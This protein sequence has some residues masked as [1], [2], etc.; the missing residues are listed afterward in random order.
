MPEYFE[1]GTY[2]IVVRPFGKKHRDACN[3][4]KDSNKLPQALHFNRSFSFSSYTNFVVLPSASFWDFT[5]PF[6]YAS[7]SEE[8]GDLYFGDSSDVLAK[9]AGQSSLYKFPGEG[10]TVISGHNT[11]IFKNLFKLKEEDEVVIETVYGKFNYKVESTDIVDY[12]KISSLDKECD[13][14]LYTCY[15]EINIYGNKRLIVYL[16]LTDSSWVGDNNEG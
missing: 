14:I 9:G 2:Q 1:A 5:R 6:L 16:K 12:K 3:Y 4:E 13:L 8:D 11:G 10:K 15:P 7:P